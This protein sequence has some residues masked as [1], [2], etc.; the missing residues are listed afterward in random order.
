MPCLR[1]ERHQVEKL[2]SS[3]A[4]MEWVN[5]VTSPMIRLAA[6]ANSVR[7]KPRRKAA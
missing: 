6:V 5:V 1:G 3:I 7:F 2:R 4:L